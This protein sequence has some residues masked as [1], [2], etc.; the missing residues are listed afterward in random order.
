MYRI[1]LI[2]TVH[3]EGGNCNSHELY[4]IINQISPGWRGRDASTPIA[5]FARGKFLDIHVN[6][7]TKY[8]LYAI[9]NNSLP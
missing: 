5:V 4:K 9:F 7:N 8:V 1:T 3:R 6:G 2:A